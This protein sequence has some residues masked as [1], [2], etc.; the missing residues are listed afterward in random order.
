MIEHRKQTSHAYDERIADAIVAAI[1]KSYVAECEALQRRLLEL[2]R[3][4]AR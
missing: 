3:K 4:D 2:E 1:L